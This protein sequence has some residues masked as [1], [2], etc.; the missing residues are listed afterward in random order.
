MQQGIAEAIARIVTFF[1]IILLMEMV[2]AGFTISIFFN[3]F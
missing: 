1:V 2:A 3:M